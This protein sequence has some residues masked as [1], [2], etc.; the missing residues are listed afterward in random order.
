MAIVGLG[1]LGG[2]VT[3][4][5]SPPP[6][7]QK[8]KASYAMGVAVARNIQRRRVE[9]DANALER[10]IRDA[11]A[12]G[13]LAMTDEELRSTMVALEDEARKQRQVAAPSATDRKAAGEAY[14]AENAKKAGVVTLASGVQYKILEAGHGQT[15]T[16]ADTVACHY[17]GTLIDGRELESSHRRGKPAKITIAQTLP[18]WRE[19][20]K[21]MPVGSTWQVVVPPELGPVGH[22]RV[23]RN[24]AA[25]NETLV[26]ELE[27]L[28]IEPRRIE[29]SAKTAG[30]GPER[31]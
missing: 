22:G 5:E 15:P 9:V 18:A 26:F 7:T 21:L 16:E 13:K 17:R 23:R 1:L 30:V 2:Q 3:A 8:E 24:N 11:L 28:S 14:R 31:P 27:L 6:E 25:R 4:R 29:A 10:G 20:L 12:G 19:V